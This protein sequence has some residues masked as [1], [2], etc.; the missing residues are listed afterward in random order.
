M[1]SLRSR[2]DPFD[3]CSVKRYSKNSQIS[4]AITRRTIH[5][6]GVTAAR[7]DALSEGISIAIVKL[8][9][10]FM[11]IDTSVPF[12]AVNLALPAGAMGSAD[13]IISNDIS[14][15]STPT[16]VHKYSRITG[17]DIVKGGVEVV[18]AA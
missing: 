2:A 16:S 14:G 17:N 4:T 9:T 5:H 18:G 15:A 10:Q 12:S 8:G 7:K 6:T 11:V 3:V 13:W 1:R